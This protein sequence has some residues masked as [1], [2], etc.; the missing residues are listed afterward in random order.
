[1]K[2]LKSQSQKVSIFTSK[3]NILKFLQSRLKYSKIERILDFTVDDWNKNKNQILQQVKSTFY[4]KKVIIRSSAIGEDSDYSSEAGSYESILNINS[5]SRTQLISAINKVIKSYAHK[6]NFNLKNQILIQT[7]AVDIIT[8]GVIFS[9]TP[10]NGAPYYVIN[11]EDGISTI[12]V[13]HGSVG[14][15]IKIARHLGIKTIGEKWKSLLQSVKE[16]ET[17]VQ[18]NSLDIEFGITKNSTIVIFQVRPITSILKSVSTLDKKIIKLI[19]KNKNQ[20]LSLKNQKTI[21]NNLIFSDM[22]DWNP[23]EIIGNNPKPLD[24][25]LYD[26]LIMSDAWYKG[27]ELLGYKNFFPH[28]LMKKFGNKPYVDNRYSFYSLIPEKFNRKLSKKLL[29]FYLEKLQSNPQLHD[30]VE[31]EILFTCYDF[32]L[33]D[34]LKELRGCNFTKNEI[35]KIRNELFSFTE[36][37][38]KNFPY[39]K[40]YCTKL[41]DKMYDNRLVVPKINR[42]SS[43]YVDKLSI[44]ESLLK[45]CK[46]FGTIPFS[47]MARI[48]FISSIIIKSLS[49]KN[50]F[51]EKL[52]HEFMNSLETPLSKFQNDLT[53]YYENKITKE[54]FLKKYGHLRPGTYDITIDRY[55]RENKFLENITFQQ[56]HTRKPIS[57]FSRKF[58]KTSSINEFDIDPESFFLFLKD[59]II[60]R[61]NLKFE[62]TQ[63][64]SNAIELIADAGKDL[65]FF[66]NDLSY[67]EIDKIL[68][69]YRKLSK[70]EFIN[71]LKICIDKNKNC[72]RLNNYLVLPSFISSE[73]DFDIINLRIAK[74]NFITQK[75][76]TSNLV[77]LDKKTHDTNFNNKIILLE[78]ADPGF[79]WI[80]TRN[81][82]GLITKYGGVASHMSIRCSELN[83]PAAIG[84]GSIIYDQIKDASKIL[85]D[86]KNQQII[87]LEFEKSNQNNEEKKILKSLGYIK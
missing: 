45:D 32:T 13:T 26:F 22:T 50:I 66:R 62:F 8:S 35:Q 51:T 68:K 81:P 75:S 36:E 4:K 39:W 46:N 9:R 37:I 11:F 53:K 72:F 83:L 56:H 43:T 10:D 69:N 77:N 79:D 58:Q 21:S 82:S 15:T 55:D 52:V 76:V 33:D 47:L 49:K 40:D 5:S 6:K 86:C 17:V 24:Y 54:S 18:S 12:G 78:H 64:L 20:F 42:K 28:S 19:N 57:Y 7:Q 73:K 80:F 27:R 59:S 1:M 63:N 2:E 71:Y 87:P 74:P 16:I 25:S 30:K 48:A 31:F 65:G 70:I 60:L 23:A 85:L 29:T 84:C 61:E 67:L 34:R 44:A 41:I 14:N 38:I 3:S